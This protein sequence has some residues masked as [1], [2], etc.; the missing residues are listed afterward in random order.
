[1]IEN[2][3]FLALTVK[4]ARTGMRDSNE[5]EKRRLFDLVLSAFVC[6]I[7]GERLFSHGIKKICIKQRW[8]IDLFSL[9][10]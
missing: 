7:A 1:M 3:L 5:I 2:P 9:S 10:N 8:I 6:M 4:Y